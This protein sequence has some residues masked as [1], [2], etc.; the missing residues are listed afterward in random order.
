MRVRSTLTLLL[1][2][3]ALVACGDDRGAVEEVALAEIA[4]RQQAFEGRTL[5]VRGTVR[6][7]HD[8]RH[9]WL[10]D[11]HLNRVGLVPEELIA[12]HLGR[13]VTVVGRY[14][15]ARDRGRRITITSI[16]PFDSPR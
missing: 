6:G 7:F 9:Y 3:F 14:T 16:E 1:V 10:E 2:T 15:F 8:P 13:E 12:P 5:R 4:S 11:D